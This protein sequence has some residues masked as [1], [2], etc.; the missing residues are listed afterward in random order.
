[1]SLTVIESSQKRYEEL[2]DLDKK[3]FFHPSTSF[4][5]QKEQGPGLIFT[6][7]KGIYLKDVRG[8]ELIDSLSSLWNV[9]I[10][11]GRTELAEA[12][13]EQMKKLAFSST[14]AGNSHEA[15]IKLSAKVAEM[16]P[17]DLNYTFFTS[18]GSE[19]NDT[20]FKT[21]RYYWKM[22]GRPSKKKIISRIKSYH[23]VSVGASA[24]T[25][26]EPFRDFPSL[27]PDFHY[28]DSSIEALK[29][30]IER[31]GAENIAA[32]ISEPVQGSG[33]VN[34]PP[35]NFFKELRELCDQNEILLIVDEVIN[36]FYRTGTNFGIDNFEII[37]DIMCIAKGISSGYAPIGG[38]IITERL[39]EELT[40]LT[41]GV[42]MHG[43]TYSGHPMCCAVAL[44]NLELIEEEKL[45]ENVNLMGAELLKGFKYLQEAHEGIG[46]IRQ[47]GL[48]G[49][50][51]FFKDIDSNIRYEEPLAPKVVA[52]ALNNDMIARAIIY[53]G[54]DTLAFAPPFCIT[55]DEVEKMISII[56]K[57]IKKVKS[58]I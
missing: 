36:G 8:R 37:P 25:G 5:L 52:E 23:G 57:S 42:F 4:K 53:E 20:A 6:E 55:K 12:A 19:S 32:I 44:K 33:G 21:A 35:E 11:H 46:N 22:K 24:A 50:I 28:V 15:V 54:Q 14:F 30:M 51:E 27:A 10:G 34:L 29:E 2:A 39:K 18:G 1:M 17:G 48:L 7:G 3:H 56:D 9:N 26:L 38:M 58:G 43:Y 45:N 16:T 40:D 31:E 41:N 47:I 49:A 13:A